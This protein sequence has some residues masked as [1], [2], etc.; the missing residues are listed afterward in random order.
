MESQKCIFCR[1][2]S[3]DLHEVQTM[4]FGPKYKEMAMAMGDDL[5]VLRFDTGDLIA[6][7]AKYHHCCATDFRNR[8][9]SFNQVKISKAA[10]AE[11]LLDERAFFELVESMKEDAANGV[12]IFRMAQLTQLFD[13]RRKLFLLPTPGT[14]LKNR[15]LDAFHGDL[16]EQF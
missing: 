8:Y 3:V 12:K 2:D 7:E 14:R 15:I 4:L 10:Q 6:T 5:M 11:Q 9:R 1:L 16:V 13:E